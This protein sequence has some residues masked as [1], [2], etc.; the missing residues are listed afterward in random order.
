MTCWSHIL[1]PARAMW[2]TL[3]H[4]RFDPPTTLPFRGIPQARAD[5]HGQARC[6]GCGMCVEQ[7]PTDCIDIDNSQRGAA[8][9]V[10]WRRCIA[11]GICVAAC[12]IQALDVETGTTNW[13]KASGT[14]Q[15]ADH[16][17]VSE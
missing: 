15:D 3:R 2:I 17:E 6:D 14:A 4:A 13:F 12:P 1:H 16:K 10:D 9:R 7:C 11:C 8:F 5:A